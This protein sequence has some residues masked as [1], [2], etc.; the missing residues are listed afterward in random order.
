MT[1]LYI[2]LE[3]LASDVTFQKRLLY[4]LKQ[5]GFSLILAGG[6]NKELIN[7]LY[8]GSLRWPILAFSSYAVSHPLVLQFG[9]AIT[10]ANLQTVVNDVFAYLTA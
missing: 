5:K 4:G 10:D 9:S 1:A 7:S 3:I 6:T 2:D 8:S